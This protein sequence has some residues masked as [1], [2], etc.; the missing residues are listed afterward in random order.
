M[1]VLC[2]GQQRQQRGGTGPA[3]ALAALSL[4]DVFTLGSAGSCQDLQCS[5]IRH[6]CHVTMPLVDTSSTDQPKCTIKIAV[7]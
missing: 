6:C 3:I 7:Q 2:V 1:Y 5:V 4:N